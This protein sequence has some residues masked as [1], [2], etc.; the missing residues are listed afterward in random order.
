MGTPGHSD[1]PSPGRLVTGQAPIFMSSRRWRVWYAGVV[2]KLQECP[3]ESWAAEAASLAL[4]DYNSA[5]ALLYAIICFASTEPRYQ[6]IAVSLW[7]QLPLTRKITAYLASRDR[8]DPQMAD[9]GER[10]QRTCL[11]PHDHC[12][13]AIDIYTT[14]NLACRIPDSL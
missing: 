2:G 7:S 11:H 4:C 14:D 1:E 9:P 10:R 5:I 12:I 13:G 3:A 6:C 8:M